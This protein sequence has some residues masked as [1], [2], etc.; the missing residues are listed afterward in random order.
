MVGDTIKK[1]DCTGFIINEE[2]EFLNIFNYKN[3]KCFKFPNYIYIGQIKES[4]ET[5]GIED[6][7]N[8]TCINKKKGKE[9]LGNREKIEKTKKNVKKKKVENIIKE[10]YGIL[11]S[12]KK[13]AFNEE[14][15]VNK[16][17]GNWKN[18]KKSGLGLNIYLNK[19][20]YYGYYINDMK[21]GYGNFIWNDSKS[22]YEGN[23][24]NNYMQ[25]I[26]KYKNK[27]YIFDG[28]FHMNKFINFNGEWI[29]IIE[30]EKNNSKNNRVNKQII[31][32]NNID[33]IILP[34]NFLKVNLKKIA[35]TIKYNFNKVP[36]IIRS[37]NFM[38]KRKQNI[39]LSKLIFLSY[40]LNTLEA[41]NYLDD[42]QL[43]FDSLAKHILKNQN[44][45][46]DQD[47]NNYNVSNFDE[48]E[49][50]FNIKSDTPCSH[51]SDQWSESS[52]SNNTDKIC[53]NDRS[54]E[55][56]D[57]ITDSNSNDSTTSYGS[58]MSI[59]SNVPEICSK[60]NSLNSIKG[61]NE[62]INFPNRSTL[63]N[64]IGNKTESIESDGSEL[65]E[66]IKNRNSSS[67]EMNKKEKDAFSKSGSIRESDIGNNETDNNLKESNCNS[68]NREYYDLK[69]CNDSTYVNIEKKRRN[70]INKLINKYINIYNN[71]ESD[72]S[73]YSILS[74]G[75]ETDKSCKNDINNKNKTEKMENEENENKNEKDKEENPNKI[76]N[77]NNK[78]NN[79]DDINKIVK[80]DILKIYISIKFLKKLRKCNLSC[81]YNI[82]KKIKNSLILNYPFIFNLNY[83]KNKNEMALDH[84]FIKNVT[85]PKF[86]NLSNYFGNSMDKISKDIFTPL[87]FDFRNE[88]KNIFNFSQINKDN[89]VNLENDSGEKHS[90]LNF[91]MVTDLLVDD[92][93]DI[94][95]LK[96]LLIDKFKD[97]L[98][99][100]NLFFIIIE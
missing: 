59:F 33:L 6:N 90:N 31:L 63:N 4:N 5:E 64:L 47:H 87:Y 38:D 35:N 97:C 19:N 80:N 50:E 7:K 88:N 18:N 91:F 49:S 3:I 75:K 69:I 67:I 48:T 61:D 29:D 2:D 84:L 23:W 15:I 89:K 16:F 56:E 57:S 66:Y 58:R 76:I 32:N 44:I 100:N 93:N 77:I 95:Y 26:G 41:E 74:R 73:E 78:E 25:G 10:G 12:L 86:W 70:E 72:S 79:Y 42:G 99:V 51:A 85:I 43:A 17:I 13:N 37:K 1:K 55:L 94:N 39:D 40:C 83:G 53:S 9:E 8:E 30:I 45:N 92:T 82:N 27:N 22:T 52:T 14:I 62:H 36:F 54:S 46:F 71:C 96:S 60:K 21:S 65:K 68:K 11:L 81:T 20:I 24:V 34:F 28:N 98:Y